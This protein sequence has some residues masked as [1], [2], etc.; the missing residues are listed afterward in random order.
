[1]FVGNYEP[2]AVP[3][4]EEQKELEELLRTA[5]K[6]PRAATPAAGRSAARISA[7]A[8]ELKTETRDGDLSREVA[9][10]KPPKEPLTGRWR[11]GFD[12]RNE[13]ERPL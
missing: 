4:P 2:D 9:T 3:T 1:M 8:K 7:D 11:H 12:Q 6:P 10:P 13:K 5:E